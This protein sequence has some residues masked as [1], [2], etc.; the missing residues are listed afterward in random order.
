MSPDFTGHPH[1]VADF[2][3]WVVLSEVLASTIVFLWILGK[4]YRA[5]GSRR[6][7]W[8]LMLRYLGHLL[9]A[10]GIAS[11]IF[12]RI[13]QPFNWFVTP[14]IA[15]GFSVLIVSTWLSLGQNPIHPLEYHEET[16]R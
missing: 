14:L 16:R 15:V 4:T 2:V 11:F 3:R 1:V 10:I 9:V 5:E 7:R 13:G 8:G 6:L 12:T